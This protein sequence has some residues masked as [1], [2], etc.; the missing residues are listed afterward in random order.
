MTKDQIYDIWKPAESIWSPWVKA[1]L[2]SY[3]NDF[4]QD[5]GPL[6]IK[7]L[8]VP[9]AKN[10][11][12]VLNLPG[13]QGVEIG[14]ALAK[15]SGFR[16]V[17]VYNACPYATYASAKETLS[18]ILD[19]PSRPAYLIPVMVDVEPIMQA[20]AAHAEPLS[21]ASLAPDAPPAFLLD[22]NRQSRSGIPNAESGYFDNRSFLSEFDFPSAEYLLQNGI[23]QVIL[24]Q[25]KAKLQAD[26]KRVLLAWQTGGV[27]IAEQDVSA[28]G[29]P[30]S[31]H[32]QPPNGIQRLWHRF[33]KSMGLAEQ[34]MDYFGEYV[35][36]PS[37]G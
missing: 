13:A 29:N 20:L 33:T 15:Q 16:P 32:I 26:L 35:P 1:V 4:D 8:N 25:K 30:K 28:Q 23:S 14:W 12:V 19:E 31:T 21:A 5:C 36:P 22:E 11:A 18:I 7:A 9:P 10:T 27:A 6:E 3:M 17:P 2:F 37:S 24:I 34:P